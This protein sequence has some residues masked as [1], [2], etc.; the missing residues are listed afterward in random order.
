MNSNTIESLNA[1]FYPKNLVIYEASEKI[2]YFILGLEELKFDKKKLYL[3]NPSK[4]EISGIK[5]YK[6]LKD[7]PE[8]TIDHLI[9]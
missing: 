2:W 7:V 6:A 9:L 1:L 5:C 3:I 4:E 8:D